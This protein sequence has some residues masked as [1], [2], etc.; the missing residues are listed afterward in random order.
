MYAESMMDMAC[1]ARRI[2]FVK[3]GGDIK[4]GEISVKPLKRKRERESSRKH[5]EDYLVISVG[6]DRQ[7]DD[8]YWGIF[9]S[10]ENPEKE[11]H[12]PWEAAKEGIQ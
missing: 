4:K 8:A 9:H 7:I 11:R 3:G 1:A 10:R 6:G 2:F 5:W 12:M